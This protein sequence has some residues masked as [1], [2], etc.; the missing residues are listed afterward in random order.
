MTKKKQYCPKS[1]KLMCELGVLN[2]AMFA[3]KNHPPR[4]IF[5]RGGWFN[6]VFRT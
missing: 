2:G 6:M 5:S 3:Q 1:K 4:I